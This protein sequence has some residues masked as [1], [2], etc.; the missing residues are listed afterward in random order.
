MDERRAGEER[1][2][3][4]V[5]HVEMAV[6]IG[7]QQE[8]AVLPAPHAVDQHHGLRR[9]PVVAVVRREL[10]VP[11]ALARSR[12]SSATTEFVNRLSPSPRGEPVE[13]RRRI[14]DRPVQR[15]ELGIVAAGQPRG[16]AAG[17]PAVALP[18][19]VAELARARESCRTATAACRSTS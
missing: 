2:V 13:D 4:A 12:G 1:A 16:S 7:V 11:L 5:E 17:L 8:L 14:A 18:G 15:V 3:R 6:A 10:I 19:V 9:V